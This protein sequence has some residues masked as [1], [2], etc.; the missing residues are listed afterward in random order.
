MG[1]LIYIGVAM[2]VLGLVG[3]IYCI[4]AVAK[5]KKA[6]LD[7]DAMKAKLQKIV[8]VN[9]GALGVSGLGLAMVIVGLFMG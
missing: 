1:I 7:E 9:L 6:G 5:A 4:V 2:T 3:I 8:A